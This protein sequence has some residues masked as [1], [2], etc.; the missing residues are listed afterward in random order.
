VL[1]AG[2][3]KIAR[4]P[5]HSALQVS[6]NWFTAPSYIAWHSVIDKG[7]QT[8]NYYTLGSRLLP[9]ASCSDATARAA[10][11]SAIA[12]IASYVDVQLYIVRL[13]GGVQ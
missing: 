8:G 5:H 6:T 13:C 10:A 2:V 12:T 9:A 11:V 1:P 4:V 7:D 3:G